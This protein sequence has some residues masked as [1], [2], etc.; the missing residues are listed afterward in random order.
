MAWCLENRRLGKGAGGVGR[1]VGCFL[2]VVAGLLWAI[3]PV[4]AGEP[5]VVVSIKPVHSLVASV[6]EGVGEPVL[7]VES[8]GSPHGYT[9]KPSQAAALS[10]ADL[11]V[12]IGEGLESYLSAPI[13]S[14]VRG[15]RVLE[16]ADLA[17]IAL[18]PLREGGV[19]EPHGRDDTGH[20]DEKHADED[21]ADEDH[22]HEPGHAG[23]DPHLWLD[24]QNALVMARIV[25]DRLIAL[26]PGHRDAYE[27]NLAALTGEIERLDAEAA[28]ALAPVRDRPYIVFHDAFQYFERHYE[29]AGAGAILLD[30]E[31]GASAARLSAIRDRLAGADVVCAFAEPQIDTGLLETV[32]EDTAVRIAPLDPEGLGLKPGPE[33]YALLMGDVVRT[34]T[35]CLGSGD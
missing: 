25:A 24:P 30:P 21:P 32:V 23:Y 14:L 29:L 16:L 22:A 27:E 31:Q 9:L 1:A 28:A 5:S 3:A 4:R 19:W 34:M 7:L 17:G 18:L 33:L 20:A 35:A 10:D 6:M 2:V 13:A 8:G 15:D 11:V 12:W 26:D